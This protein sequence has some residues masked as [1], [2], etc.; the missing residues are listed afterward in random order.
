[1][2]YVNPT[3]EKF[4]LSDHNSEYVTNNFYTTK[5]F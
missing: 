2:H 1:M 4:W 5:Y 3:L